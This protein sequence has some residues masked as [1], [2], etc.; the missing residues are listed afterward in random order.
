MNWFKNLRTVTKLMM[1][2]GVLAAIMIYVGYLGVSSAQTLN[3][4]LENMYQKDM[5]GTVYIKDAKISRLEIA[6]DT[7][8]AILSTDPAVREAKVQAANKHFTDMTEQLAEAEKCMVTEAGKAQMA[9]V[10]EVIP[11][12]EK[13]QKEIGGLA[14]AGKTAETMKTLG[15]AAP[16]LAELDRALNQMIGIKTER[17]K[18]SYDESQGVVSRVHTTIIVTMVIALL[19]SMS[20]GYFIARLIA[21]PL[22]AAVD[23][24]GKVADGDLT[25]KLDLDTRDEVGQMATALNA[26]T[27]AMRNALDEVRT[28]ADNMAGSAQELASASQQLASGAQEQAS[29]LEET[30]ATM[31]EITSTI[32]QNAD[33]ANQASQVASASRETAEKGGHVVSD[34]VS[35]MGEIN[36]ASK[37]IA[38]IITTIDEIAF[39]TNLLALNAA[40]EAARA[41]VQ[42][43]GFAVVATEVRNLA[44]RSA[45]SAKEIKRLIQDSVRKVENGSGLVNK[46]GETLHEIVGSV[47]R[48]TDIVSEIAA[49]SREQS[50][51]VEQVNKAMM[52]MDQV[53]QT[54]SSQ[55]EELS[56]TAQSLAAHAQQLQ[57]LVERFRLDADGHRRH[58]EHKKP[59]AKAVVTHSAPATKARA[60]AAVAADPLA[61]P[62]AKAK[63]NGHDL[64]EVD[65]FTE[66]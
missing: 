17:A 18:K 11:T 27:S 42:G 59:A 58:V 16:V 31:E 8:D 40:V 50:T 61:H 48:V 45:T 49:A 4:L 57:A 15:D 56:A 9:K 19:L 66:F 47:K 1:G 7:R 44:Q 60:H 2:F 53:T 51:G 36:Q 23:V 14:A 39:Q 54:N 13:A 26:A 46:S 62:A 3:G 55:T 37:S 43:R 63:Q 35:A 34:A 12:Y 41:G 29:S 25:A 65:A 32:K 22:V 5:V 10:K 21:Q 20:V 24:L 52:Q 28:S 30:T 33:N 64:S 38:E 6:R